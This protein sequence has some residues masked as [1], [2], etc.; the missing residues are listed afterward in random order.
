M[1]VKVIASTFTAVFLAELG[2]KTQLATFGFAAESRNLVSVFLGSAS[3]L[4]LSTLLAV[5]LGGAISEFIPTKAVHMLAGLA[6]VMI[7]VLMLL[8][9]L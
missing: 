9:K 6:F 3:A 1:D 2:D 4:I 8:G 7:G 5:I